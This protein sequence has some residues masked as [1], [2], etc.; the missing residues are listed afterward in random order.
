MA[1]LEMGLEVDAT[2]ISV[3]YEGFDT[4]SLKR[5]TIKIENNY[6]EDEVVA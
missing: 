6:N 1:R 5:L 3:L 4:V 2:Y